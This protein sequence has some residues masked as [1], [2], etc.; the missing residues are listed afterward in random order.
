[1]CDML[2]CVICV[3]CVICFVVL[4]ILI[5]Q[6]FWMWVVEMINGG[7]GEGCAPNDATTFS[8]MS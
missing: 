6:L 8:I 7:G 1:M 2:I 4:V 3:I 5:V